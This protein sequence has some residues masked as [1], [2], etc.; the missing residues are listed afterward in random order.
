MNSRRGFLFGI[1]RAGIGAMVLP[2]AT[3]YAR[4]MWIR[5]EF[6]WEPNPLWKDASYEMLFLFDATKPFPF[7]MGETR[8]DINY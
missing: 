4:S 7:N 5:R 8:R 3:T 1:L 2:A 6:I